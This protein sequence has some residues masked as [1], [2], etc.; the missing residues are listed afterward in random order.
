MRHD[1]RCSYVINN[2]VTTLARARARPATCARLVPHMSQSQGPSRR[3]TG[4]LLFAA[5][6]AGLCVGLG[7]GGGDDGTVSPAHPT[8]ESVLPSPPPSVYASNE[9]TFSPLPPPSSH[10]EA[11]LSSSELKSTEPPASPP[12]LSIVKP[13]KARTP[14]DLVEPNRFALEVYKHEFAAEVEALSR[15]LCAIKAGAVIG[16]ERRTVRASAGIRTLALVALGSSMFTLTSLMALSDDGAR[17]GAAVCTG[18]RFLGAGALNKTADRTQQRYL[19]TANSVWTSAALGVAAAAGLKFL[20]VIVSGITVA[21]LRWR[22][23]CYAA[24]YAFK[25]SRQYLDVLLKT[26]PPSGGAF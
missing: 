22:T 2:Y 7:G 18:V 8:Y 25:R 4:M 10:Y 26:L 23:I 5:A 9:T 12:V 20:A 24:L 19:R 15:I 21:V 1:T 16:T 6:A 13:K 14:R 17:M 3:R 11:T